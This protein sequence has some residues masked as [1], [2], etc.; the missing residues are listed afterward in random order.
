MTSVFYK[1]R[2]GGGCLAQKTSQRRRTQTRRRQKC[3]EIDTSGPRVWGGV[4]VM[5]NAMKSMAHTDACGKRE[6][7]PGDEKIEKQ[8]VGVGDEVGLKKMM[9]SDEETDSDEEDLIS[10]KKDI[11]SGG[12]PSGSGTGKKRPA[13]NES[14]GTDAG[15]D[16]K[17][18]K[19]EAPL[20]PEG[21][22]EET[23][24]KYLRRKPHTTK[25]LLAKIKQKCGDM[26]KAEIVTKLAAILKAIEPH[27]FKQ[28]QG[29]KDVLFFSLTNTLA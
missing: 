28:K 20:V 19:T 21:L 5:E 24:R 14:S 12:E 3:T 27:Q 26:T 11:A 29:K 16:A 4:M 8:L 2:E 15:N 22:N 1:E 23:V 13:E 25:E 6:E 9:E 7:V 17:R 10:S 18:V